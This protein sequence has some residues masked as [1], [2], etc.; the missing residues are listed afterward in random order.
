MFCPNCGNKMNENGTCDN[1]AN[2]QPGKMVKVVINRVSSFV[3]CAVSY[4]V[5]VDG[6][7]VAKL[8]NGG[9]QEIML[10]A[11]PHSFAFDM[12]S[13]TNANQV[14][15]PDNCSTFIIDTKLKMGLIKNNIEIVSTRTE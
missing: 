13:A 4:K 15:I 5:Y 7:E 11:G 14:I 12:W 2:Q 10:P 3:G 6:N 1:C 8:A 9:S